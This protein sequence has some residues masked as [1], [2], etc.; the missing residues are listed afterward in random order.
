MA[1]HSITYSEKYRRATLH[2]QGCN[3]RCRGCSYRLK[4]QR[5][6]ERLPSLGD[7]RACLRGLGLEAVHF[8]GGEP[9]TNAQLPGLLAFCKESLGVRT[10]LGH[11]NGSNLVL[12]NLDGMNV[13]FKGLTDEH[14]LDYTGQPAQP[15][16]RS[17]RTA[18]EAGLELKAS[19][20]LIPG[21]CD[22]DQV[23]GI[24]SFVGGLSRAIPFHLMGFIPVPGAP[25]SRPSEEAMEEALSAI[26][27]HVD[28]ITSS[29]L[30]SEA[31][32]AGTRHD[33]LFVVERVL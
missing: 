1:I 19:T 9:T 26:R 22:L 16:Y 8:M 30:T 6:P 25:W 20:V 28:T 14:Y 24:A 7:V 32:V 29:H 11:T 3:Y 4:P 23:E 31:L 12:T 21:Y 15:V 27:R 10:R 5:V 2:N 17:F 18:F 13:S 33:D